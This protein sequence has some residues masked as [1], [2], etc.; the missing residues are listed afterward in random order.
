MG[1]VI[2]W[3]D[4]YEDQPMEEDTTDTWEQTTVT[5]EQTTDR[6]TSEE[7]EHTA[8]QQAEISEA[9]EQTKVALGMVQTEAE[10]KSQLEALSWWA[11]T[12]T[13][14]PTLPD[15]EDED[16]EWD[17]SDDREAVENLN[18]GDH[19]TLSELLEWTKT[20]KRLLAILNDP[21]F[22]E[23]WES[24]EKR[25]ERIFTKV[26]TVITKYLVRQFSIDSQ[27]PKKKEVISTMSTAIQCFL[28]DVLKN[29]GNAWNND[30][31]WQLTSILDSLT[32][33]PFDGKKLLEHFSNIAKTWN[34]Y[35]QKV[36]RLQ[37]VIDF[38]SLH[39]DVLK[40]ADQYEEFSDPC[41]FYHYI[42]D[43]SEDS[44]NVWTAIKDEEIADLNLD[45]IKLTRKNWDSWD[46]S[47]EQKK[48]EA[49][50]ALQMSFADIQV[51]KNSNTTSKIVSIL[52]KAEMFLD[53][54]SKIKDTVLGIAQQAND[55]LAIFWSDVQSVI[56]AFEDSPILKGIA[57]MFLSFIGFPWGFSGLK[58][59]LD[60]DYATTAWTETT[61]ESTESHDSIQNVWQVK[62]M[63]QTFSS[64]SWDFL[65]SDDDR[66]ALSGCESDLS[67]LRTDDPEFNQKFETIKKNFF[68]VVLKY[69]ISDLSSVVED[70]SLVYDVKK[71]LKTLITN[72]QNVKKVET[73]GSK[74]LYQQCEILSKQW[75][76]LKMKYL[77]ELMW[78][79]SKK[80]RLD[81]EKR[82]NLEQCIKDAND[83]ILKDAIISFEELHNYNKKYIDLLLEE[84]SSFWEKH[85]WTKKYTQKYSE[86]SSWWSSDSW[87]GVDGWWGTVDSDETWSLPSGISDEMFT[88]LKLMEW[89]QAS[90]EEGFLVAK[91]H[92]RDFWEHFATWPYGMVYKRIDQDGKPLSQ[93][94]HFFN[95][96]KV[97]KERAEKNA[98]AY[99][100]RSAKEWKNVLQWK[101]YTQH[102]FDA[103][104]S[105]SWWTTASKKAL[106]KFVLE[107]WDTPSNI[108]GYLLTFAT[109][110]AWDGKVK[111][112][113]VIRRK[114]ESQWFMW[115]TK[116]FSD[117]GKEYT[118]DHPPKKKG[119]SSQ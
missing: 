79:F 16:E 87:T 90:S 114:F 56:D 99:Y 19:F 54:S 45:K 46:P 48:I 13:W 52:E 35:Y 98:R 40:Q 83:S 61:S 85:P 3:Y 71:D 33:S 81:W 86:S 26:D 95:G 50:N 109:K 108:S 44:P 22:S 30:I 24:P 103:L 102:Q 115:G 64:Q 32:N 49:I 23:L 34:F 74:D 43:D 18:I 55:V 113:L 117:C 15:E 8:D 39:P 68:S 93:A 29:G 27:D 100:D 7:S 92:S 94:S 21:Q 72:A 76:Q 47:R 2:W 73:S 5:W 60:S 58:R 11:T 4:D 105:A 63:I 1:D 88:Q 17:L 75:E 77:V 36:K 104:V 65:S 80:D 10:T 84:D 25:L 9:I 67:A 107:N 78:R 62:T 31:L 14:T 51:V 96:E 89:E 53:D 111:A 57:S 70:E 110:A 41:S 38:F 119:N 28:I 118:K 66:R 12:E 42:N 116:T 91:T 59:A 112:W 69:R 101:T 82:A 20:E 6:W 97:T 37:K 106:Q